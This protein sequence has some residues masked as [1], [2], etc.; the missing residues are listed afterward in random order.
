MEQTKIGRD[1]LRAMRPGETKTFAYADANGLFSARTT[2][3]QMGKIMGCRFSCR[4]EEESK[5]VH[6]TRLN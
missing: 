3:H 6:V 5:L 2:A 4:T 1:K